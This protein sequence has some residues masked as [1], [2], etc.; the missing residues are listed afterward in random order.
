M[1]LKMIINIIRSR[2]VIYKANII[3]GAL[4]VKQPHTIIVESNFINT[5]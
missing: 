5:K 3:D 1:K 4:T 2:P